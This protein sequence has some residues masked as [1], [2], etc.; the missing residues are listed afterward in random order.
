MQRFREIVGAVKAQATKREKLFRA[1]T[2]G[3]ILD[4]AQR[5]NA[6]RLLHSEAVAVVTNFYPSLFGGPV[7]QFLK[8]LT[9]VK[10]CEE[11]AKDGIVSVPVCWI[12]STAPLGFSTSSVNLLDDES[13]LHRFQLPEVINCEPVPSQAPDILRQI[14]EVGRGTYDTEVLEI[15][16]AVLASSMPF[17]SPTARLVEALMKELGLIV[18]DA[19]A[20]GFLSILNEA[21]API[22]S[23]TENIQSLMQKKASELAASGYIGTSSEDEDI[24]P[25][26]LIPCLVLPAIACVI[27]PYEIY[28]YA[29]ALPIFDEALVPRPVAWPRSSA[30]ILDV[31]SR[32]ILERYDLTLPR[33]YSG[34]E[35]V[36]KN[37]LEVLPNSTP[38]KIKSLKLEVET[39]MAELAARVST[40]S[41]F[42][43]SAKS[44]KEKI[45]YQLE[46][47]QAQFEAAMQRKE[48]A[49]R[50]R[51]HR[52]CNFLAPN[53]RIQE[54]ELAGIQIPLRYSRG[55]LRS[56]CEKLDVVK[57]EHQLIAM[58]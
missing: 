28:G 15:L 30:T 14:K 37:I 48:Q 19:D 13:E 43:D 40:R 32:R 42:A 47:L 51:I 18:L 22:R 49:L 41:E 36:I 5:E 46:K 55:G 44:C 50:R 35:E 4:S 27:D 26:C 45:I 20:P 11:L 7:S 25:A 10:V 16:G 52:A 2:N 9:A 58:D 38:E 54:M 53:R 24:I 12:S 21:L 29:K 6:Q 31:R 23:Q 8:C 57:F 34:E 3:G 56:L 1:L 17:P 39:R 33:L